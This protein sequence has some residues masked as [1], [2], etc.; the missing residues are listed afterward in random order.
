[1]E[2]TLQGSIPATA[3]RDVSIGSAS[4]SL[5]AEQYLKIET[6]PGGE[7]VLNAQVPA[8]KAWSVVIHITVC[9]SDA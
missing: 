8:G 6:S 9:E 5:T 3:A 2:L 4:V 7:E 1:M